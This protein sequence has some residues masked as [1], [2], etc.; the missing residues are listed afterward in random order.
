M[1]CHGLQ[2]SDKDL[3]QGVSL[4]YDLS[5]A[6]LRACRFADG[7]SREFAGVALVC[8][9]AGHSQLFP[10]RAN[11]QEIK[12]RPMPWPLRNAGV[13]PVPGQWCGPQVDFMS[14]RGGYGQA[15]QVMTQ[16]LVGGHLF[17][18]SCGLG[19]GQSE[20]MAFHMPELAAL[21]FFLSRS[22]WSDP[23]LQNP[24]IVLGARIVLDGLDGTAHAT[25]Y[26]LNSKVPMTSDLVEVQLASQSVKVSSSKPIIAFSAESQDVLGVSLNYDEM[27]SARVNRL[28]KRLGKIDIWDRDDLSCHASYV[29]C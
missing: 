19:G 15:A 14:E 16:K 28:M 10:D 27:Q 26:T 4:S 8:K 13:P 24:T 23:Q 17:G 6:K 3:L 20:R 18:I 5:L 7:G 12:L 1:A 22:D 21:A 25:D 9:H 2:V 11:M 29:Q